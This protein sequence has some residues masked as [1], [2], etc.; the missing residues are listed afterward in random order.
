MKQPKTS[1]GA[2]VEQ[3]VGKCAD[4]EVTLA[5]MARSSERRA[6]GVAWTAIAMSLLLG[7]G[8]YYML[9]L[10][11]KV[12][13]L[14]MADAYTGTST[15]A[16]LADESVHGQLTSSEAINRSN[17][18]HYL[19]ARESYDIDMMQ[20]RDWRLVHTMSSPGVAAG[21]AAAHANN[22]TQAP[23][24][25]YGRNRAIRAR[26]LSL[27]LIGGDK[28]V[29]PKGATVRFQRSLYDKTTG[30]SRPLDSK[31]ATLEFEYKS[32]LKMDEKERIE[33]PLGFQ[34]TS[35]RVDNDYAPAP[36]LDGLDLPPTAFTADVQRR[37]PTGLAPV[38]AEAGMPEEAVAPLAAP[39]AEGIE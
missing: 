7:G 12:P 22:N 33:N 38:V 13:F 17:I 31:I 29:A 25:L 6:W 39:V 15:I 8:Y 10:K 19:L 14:V 34:V 23:Y 32:N 28:G 36:P 3:M 11:E 5:D 21:Y 27:V 24:H 16:R 1:T 4:F 26:I 20:L 2:A 9:P 37:S 18:A 30:S 35:Y